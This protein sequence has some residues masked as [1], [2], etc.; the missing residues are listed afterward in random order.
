M[1]RRAKDDPGDE[2]QPDKRTGAAQSP[3]A[4]VSCAVFG[5]WSGSSSSFAGS[6]SMRFSCNSGSRA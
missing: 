3:I 6:C 5:Q 1:S 2:R 4:D